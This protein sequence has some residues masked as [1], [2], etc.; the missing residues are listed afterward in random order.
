MTHI[1]RSYDAELG[2][3]RKMISDMG[4]IAENMLASAIE[5]VV[6]RDVD[7][8][9]DVIRSDKKLDALQH[10]VEER[11]VLMIARR[12][13]M[14]VD[15][16]ETIATI[17][18]SGDL[19]RI[20]DLAKNL[21]KR[22]I[23]IKDHLEHQDVVLNIQSMSNLALGQLRDV[24]SAYVQQDL[25]LALDVWRRD[26]AIDA[27]NTSVFRELLTYMMEDP[28]SITFCTH[29]MFCSKNIERIGDH[30]TNI[31]ETI[32]YRETGEILLDDRPK[33]DST[34]ISGIPRDNASSS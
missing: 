28:R 2:G 32:Y 8:A 3:L 11:A 22:T 23:V 25:D 16:R 13:P 19:E 33:V 18:I 9:Q 31:A 30:T 29:M 21:G 10:Q 15:L 12:Q 7:L 17:R 26:D 14:A 4:E 27:L 34:S 5:A 24:L 20:G 6:K 1:V